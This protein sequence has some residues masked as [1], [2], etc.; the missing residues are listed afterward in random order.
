MA[1]FSEISKKLFGTL[2]EL[3]LDGQRQETNGNPDLYQPECL[4][5]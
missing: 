3:Q 1:H 4:I 5:R 2:K